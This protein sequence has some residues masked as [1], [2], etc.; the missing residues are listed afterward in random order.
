M[1]KSINLTKIKRSKFIS[2]LESLKEGADTETFSLLNE[3]QNELNRIKYGLVWEEHSESVDEMTSTHIPVFIEK[4]EKEILFESN[5][6]INFLL[7]GDNLHSLMLLEKTHKASIDLIYIDPPYN[8]GKKDF[9]YCDEMIEP[10]DGYRHSK[11]LSFM[12]RRLQIGRRLLTD[13]GVIFIS[14]DENEMFQLKLLCDS[15]F[16]ERNYV[17]VFSVENNPK[18]RKNG[19]FISVTNEFCLIYAKKIDAAYFLKIVPKHANDMSEDDNGDFV[20]KSGKRVLMGENKLNR[21]V[22][23]F[24][25]KKHY[26]AYIKDKELITKQ[27]TSLDEY[28]EEL[29]K[30]GFTRYTTYLNDKFVENTY[31]IQKFTELFKSNSLDIRKDKIYEK[32]FSNMMQLK[33]LLVNDEYDAVVNNSKVHYKIDLKTT[34]AKQELNSLMGGEYFSFPKNVN[35]I[36]HLVSLH[37][38]NQAVILDF[39]AGSGTTG[40]AVLELNM[41]DGGQRSFILCTNN[42]ND[43][44]EKVTYPRLRTVISG[45]R[46]NGSKYSE[47]IRANLHYYKTEFIQKSLDGSISSKLMLHIKELIQLE[48]GY[49]VDNRETV[50][51]YSEEELDTRFKEDI[52]GCRRLFIPTNVFLTA[53][54]ENKLKKLK[55]DVFVIPENYFS[56]EL[57]EVDEL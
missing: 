46:P 57:R 49:L 12:N 33:S 1:D 17:G 23:D 38:N 43:I 2:K 44:C 40:Q 48:F 18:G 16:D 50:L 51:V 3:I 11:W 10:E 32:H 45:E 39:F 52:A 13:E 19:K 41:E 24:S 30:Q 25:S 31:T 27:E 8:T 42:E 29:I 34:S 35:F 7:E 56:N 28:D 4:K 20:R 53:L 9:I 5:E 26:S 14:I 54:Q 37:P 21:Y 15:I 22:S 6:K 36:K 47:G 55:V